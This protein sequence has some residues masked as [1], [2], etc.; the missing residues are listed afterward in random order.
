MLDIGFKV[1]GDLD[2]AALTAFIGS[3]DGYVVKWYDQSGTGLDASQSDVTKQPKIA[4]AGV[5]YRENGKP[6][7]LYDGTDDHIKLTSWNSRGAD[8]TGFIVFKPT[9]SEGNSVALWEFGTN[10]DA[11][12]WAAGGNTIYDGFGTNSRRSVASPLDLDQQTNVASVQIYNYES[13]YWLNGSPLMSPENISVDWSGTPTIGGTSNGRRWAGSISE[14]VV[15]NKAISII[16]RQ[17]IE[18]SEGSYYGVGGTTGILTQP[19]TINQIYCVGNIT[20]G[21]SVVAKGINL[22]FQW[23]RNTSNSNTG[24][25]LITGETKS[26]IIPSSATAGSTYYY[27][28]VTGSDGIT[29]V[30]NPSGTITINP[31]PSTG[32]CKDGLTE[33]TAGESGMQLRTDYPA[34]ESGWYWIKSSKMPNA[35]Q[36]Y[37]DM[38]EDG[39]GYD[40]YFITAGPSVSTVTEANGGTPLGLDL[41]MPRSKEHWKAMSNTVLQA[42]ADNKTGGGNYDN[43]FQTAYGVYRSNDARNGN[44]NYTNKIMRSK[45][46][47]GTNNV[48]DWRVKDGGRWWLRDETYGEPNGDY[49]PNGLLGGGGLPNPY[50]LTNLNFNDLWNNYSTGP[51]YLVSTN[52]KK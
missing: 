29:V 23:Y 31:Q 50:N 32:G 24:G 15:Y 22:S 16:E 5:I 8:A 9:A 46:Y 52:A 40:F 3:S 36:M 26:T 35:L 33:A 14:I 44:G 20:T 47:G 4:T 7:I 41:V 1:N 27:V 51:F 30:S 34:Y 45:Y 18:G 2:D 43:F 38:V 25:T 19:S 37:V 12:Y 13:Q 21:I 17:N 42:I 28:T 6:T 11:S 48:P 39:G 49:G 10:T